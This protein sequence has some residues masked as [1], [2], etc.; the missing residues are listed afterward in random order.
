MHSVLLGG[1]NGTLLLAKFTESLHPTPPR[2][3]DI[4]SRNNEIIKQCNGLCLDCV[5]FDSPYKWCLFN[6]KGLSIGFKLMLLLLFVTLI[7]VTALF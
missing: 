4:D 3:R 6:T 2:D 5:R 7:K 1:Y